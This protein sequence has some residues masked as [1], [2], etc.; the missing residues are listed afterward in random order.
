MT[1]KTEVISTIRAFCK[2]CSG[3]SLKEVRLCP[4][5][6]CPFYGFRMGKDPNPN[7]KWQGK[8]HEPRDN[9]NNQN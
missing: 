3:G 4:I 8:P 9:N 2:E 6:R 5:Q 7:R 1:T